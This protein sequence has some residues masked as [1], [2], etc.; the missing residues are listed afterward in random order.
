MIPFLST[1]MYAQSQ[2]VTEL[3]AS[4]LPKGVTEYIAKNMP[5]ATI[6]RAG[7]IEEKGET[8]Y[9]AIVE[10]K[11]TKHSYLF[12]KD[13]KF[14]GKGDNLLNSATQAPAAKPPTVTTPAPLPPVKIK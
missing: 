4:Q 5:G 9:A 8:T 12:N 13:G 14:I 10:M 7:K 6:T 11:G 1:I 2:K 3:K